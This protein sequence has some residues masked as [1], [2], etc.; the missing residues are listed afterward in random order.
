MGK[1]TIEA[2]DL[3]HAS[4][5]RVKE[6]EIVLRGCVTA[7]DSVASIK[8][9]YGSII[10]LFENAGELY[11]FDYEAEEETTIFSYPYNKP[12][13]IAAVIKANPQICPLLTESALN[14]VRE[15]YR[16]AHQAYEELMSDYNEIMLDNAKLKEYYDAA[17]QNYK[18]DPYID[19][20]KEP[21]KPDFHNWSAEFFSKITKEQFSLGPMYCMGIII[22][23]GE[24]I[25]YLV[26]VISRLS[27]EKIKFNQ[28]T[29]QFRMTVNELKRQSG[30]IEKET[31]EALAK[32]SG[33]GDVGSIEIKNAYDTIT[34]YAE[35]DKDFILE[36]K[37]D[38]D[39]FSRLKDKTDQA[40]DV[41]RL[42]RKIAEEFYRLYEKAFLKSM[43][44]AS[45][46]VEVKMFFLFGFVDEKLAGEQYTTQLA[47]LADTYKKDP[48]GKIL[49]I[50]EWLRLVYQ[51]KVEPSKNEFDMEYPA[52]LKNLYESGEIKQNQIQPMLAS[53]EE[54]AKYEIHNFFSL[55]DRITYGRISSFV[56][57]F[58]EEDYI[59]SPADS[60]LRFTDVRSYIDNI[61]S[62]DYSCFCRETIFSDVHIGVTREY[63]STEVLPYIIMMPN[64]GTRGAL[65]QEISG[66][67]RD[68]PA[69]MAIPMFSSGNT[70]RMFATLAGEFRWEMCRRE[71]GV[72]WNDVTTPSL[73]SEF[74]DYIQFYRK[75]RDITPELREKIKSQLQSARNSVKGVFVSDYVIYIEYESKGS[76]R[77]NRVSRGILFK[78]CT[79]P[80]ATRES[81]SSTL[82][83]YKELVDKY[84]IKN[85][86]KVHLMDIVLQKIE[87]GGFSIPEELKY[88]A[89]FNKR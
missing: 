33:E 29:A 43:R 44:N 78:Y 79:F 49:S 16:T 89:E 35:A 2:G 24:Y 12:D 81:L 30:N 61:R 54:R 8:L 36:F 84:N 42:R 20:L 25:N 58:Y 56:P 59:K 47:V 28:D 14:C 34:A 64:S 39:A 21:E 82:P 41:R 67:K 3:V 57:I 76:L 52:Y 75:N 51:K 32:Y 70:E 72:R 85:A 63:I 77:L 17:A 10:G 50:Y 69:R 22:F 23:A 4:N 60:V 46:P 31:E 65:W 37:K 40:D 45:I 27:D 11:R 55:T 18:P 7:M 68:T 88:Q 1:V 15:V 87:K 53:N 48:E 5:E 83:A 9:P 19:E 80:K 38:L 13:D 73:T 6:I 86:Q 62:I 74:S 71:Q 26:G 66:S